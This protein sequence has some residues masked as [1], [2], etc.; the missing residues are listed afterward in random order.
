LTILLML[1]DTV[2]SDLPD[3]SGII[4]FRSDKL[5]SVESLQSE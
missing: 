3:F 2:L 4:S 1:E 5:C